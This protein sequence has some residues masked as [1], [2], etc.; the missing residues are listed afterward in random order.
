MKATVVKRGKTLEKALKNINR[1]NGEFVEVG[2]F[3]SQG[4]HYSGLTYPELL[5]YWFIGVDIP[6]IAGKV[7]QDVR[8]QFVHDYFLTG[9]LKGDPVID[10]AIKQW[11][12]EAF[13]RDNAKTLLSTIG[14][15]LMKKYESEFNQRQGPHM[16]GTATPLYETGELAESTGYRTSRNTSVKET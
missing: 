14:Q 13:K 12:K 5:L 7:R 8:S 10:K 1:L 2:H 4:K 16:L 3:N 11:F 15:H 6:G 9:K